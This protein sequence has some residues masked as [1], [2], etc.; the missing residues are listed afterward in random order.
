MRLQGVLLEE[1]K[2]L[3]GPKLPIE[4][5]HYLSGWIES[6]SWSEVEPDKSTHELQAR[7]LFEGMLRALQDLI[8]TQASSFIV[9]TQLEALYTHMS[10]EYYSRPLELVRVIQ[11]CLYSEAALIEKQDQLLSI[12]P[13]SR[14]QASSNSQRIQQLIHGIVSR[15]E[16]ME[17]TFRQLSTKLENF[18][19]QF[20]ESFSIDNA[21]RQENRGIPPDQLAKYRERKQLLDR[22]LTKDAEEMKRICAELTQRFVDT[23]EQIAT[24]QTIVVDQELLNW[25]QSQR[26][27]NWEEDSGRMLLNQLQQWFEALVELIWRS[28]LLAK[29]FD[30]MKTR[31]PQGILQN[32][33]MT[34]VIQ[35]ITKYLV[36]LIQASFVIEKQPPQVIKTANKFSAC[37]R[38]LVGSK[39]QIHLGVP[40]VSVTIINDKQA[41]AVYGDP[42]KL[43]PPA[44][45]SGDILNNEK[46]ME[47]STQSGTLT[48]AFNFMQLRRIKRNSD[49]KA[50]ETVTEE[51]FALLF[52]THFSIGGGEFDVVVKQLSLPVVV[53]V[54]V[55]QQPQAEATIFWDNSFAEISRE[56]FI[57]PESI[58]WSHLSESLHCFFHANCGRGLTQQQLD[59][60]GR[61]VMGVGSEEDILQMNCT[62]MQLFKDQ[63]KGRNFTFWEWFYKH[64]DLVKTT[65]IREWQEGSIH[66]FLDKVDAQKL[67]MSCPGGTF[68]IR[69]SEG[70]PGG[71]SVA[72]VAD[73]DIMLNQERQMLSL[74]PWNKHD[75]GIRSLADRLHDLSQLITLCPNK[76]K[77]E[78]FGKYYA[79]PPPVEPNTDGYLQAILHTHVPFTPRAQFGVSNP[80]SPALSIV[81]MPPVTPATPWTPNLMPGTYSDLHTSNSFLLDDSVDPSNMIHYNTS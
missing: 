69:F 2:S 44:L 54:H 45:S 9:R 53:T 8:T 48:C 40:E 79:P 56:P 49:K 36:D 24:C 72:W 4:V 35:I 64:M 60:L 38:L 58:A 78:V 42:L 31:L 71:I 17:M 68:L 32:D 80:G 50:S 73:G 75:L 66:G 55:T 39:L 47:Y 34:G 16:A 76:P 3:Y 13:H 21:L 59:Y 28:R 65:L 27:F 70:D 20:Q 41:K 5:R 52:Q 10:N 22:I 63:L 6:Q 18:I 1:L 67:L 14:P 12:S 7:R 74:T 29:Q 33:I 51:K 26:K 57:V 77:N 62:R 11:H 46:N 19:I 30:L 15:T 43:A 25:K 37:V 61:K 23:Q 81:S